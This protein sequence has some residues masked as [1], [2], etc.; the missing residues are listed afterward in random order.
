VLSNDS[1]DWAPEDRVISDKMIE[2]MLTG[3]HAEGY[4][5]E[6][7]TFFN[8]LSVLDKFDPREWL[9]WN[10]GEELAGKPWTDAVVV[11]Q[12]E[13]RGF[14]FT[15]ASSAVLHF[16]QN[17]P[18]VKERLRAAGL[19]T[20]PWRVFDDPAPAAEWTH[21]PAIV[22]GANQHAS[23]GITRDSV[24][25]TPDELAR[26]I[27]L[28]RDALHDQALVEP[29]LDSRE[30]H[31]AVW[32]NDVIEVL[33]LVEY[34]FAKLSDPRERLYTYEAKFDRSS[35]AYKEIGTLCPAPAD[36]PDWEVRLREVA[37]AAYR[38]LGLRDYGRLDLRM[39]GDEPQV[40]DVN[41]NPDLDPISVFPIGCEALGLTYGQMVSRI[42]QYAAHRMPV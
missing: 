38:A 40:L 31:V 4:T 32:G 23:Y 8:D 34:D 28:L 42:V 9:I 26:A 24:A 11:A 30:F 5:C 1:P 27:V 13:R 16:L 18:R 15:G 2:L 12:L 17:R 22:K 3:L 6:L 7:V 14:T 35:R 10:W 20:L 41:P 19:P 25:F 29:F 21:Y 33:P 37:Q 36:R 39:L